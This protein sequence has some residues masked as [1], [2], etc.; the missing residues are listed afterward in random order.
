M[1]IKNINNFVQFRT[2]YESEANKIFAHVSSLFRS[3]ARLT[4]LSVILCN[5]SETGHSEAR[6]GKTDSKLKHKKT[7]LSNL[8]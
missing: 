6:T 7:L 2:F 5:L 3:L 8:T 1:K 4:L